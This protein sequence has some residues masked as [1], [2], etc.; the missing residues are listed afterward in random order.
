[1]GPKKSPKKAAEKKRARPSSSTGDELNGD[2]EGSLYLELLDLIKKLQDEDN[3]KTIQINNLQTKLDEALDEI[4]SLRSKVN[5]LKSSLEFTQSQQDEAKERIDKCE[6][7]QCRQEDELVRQS[8]YSRRWNLIFHGI[9]E[10]EGEDCSKLVT[11]ALVAN[12]KLE[13]K[14]A[15]SFMFCGTHRLGR[16]KTGNSKP[17]PIIARFTCRADRDFTWRQRFNLRD[18]AVKIAEDLPHNVREIRRDILIP[19]FK[20]ARETEGTKA[21]IIGDRLLING[22]KY[23]FDKIPKKWRSNVAQH[24]DKGLSGEAKRR[25]T[26]KWLREK[27]FQVFFLQEVH[28]TNEKRDLWQNEWGYKAL[29]GCDSSRKA[30][31]A[32]LFKNNFDFILNK[33]YI[34]P[35]GRFII[36]DIKAANLSFTLVNLYAPNKDDPSFF[37]NITNR[38]R[39]F[40]CDNIVIG[41]DFNLVLN[42][43][44]D[45]QGGNANTYHKKALAEIR[46]VQINLDVGDIWRDRNPLTTR[47]TWR[48]RNPEISCRLDFFLISC[49]LYGKVTNSDIT[50]GYKTD[51][52]MITLSLGVTENPRGPGLWKLNT[53]FLGDVDFTHRVK[54]VISQTCEDYKDDNNVDDALLWEMIKLKVREA[55]IFYGKEKAISRRK[56]ED[57]LHA[58][59][60]YLEKKVEEPIPPQLKEEL[61]QQLSE[62][63]ESLEKIYE[64]K[65]KGS[66]LRSKTRW[67]NEG[68]KNSSYFFNLEKRHFKRKVL[69]QLRQADNTTLTS[70]HDILQECVNFYSDLYSSRTIQNNKEDLDFFPRDNSVRL[71]EDCKD[72][73]EGLL[74]ANECL[75]AL[76]TMESNKSPG[77]D[78]FPA[79]FYKF[80]WNDISTLFVNAINC[81]FQKGLLSVTQRQGIVSLLPKK[82]KNPILLKNWRPITL[83]NCDYKIAAKAIGNR[84]KR[85]LPKIIDNDQSGFLKGRSIAENI[86]LIDGIINFADNTNKPGLLMFVDFEKAFDSIEWSFIE[87]ALIHFGFG[88]SLVNWFRLFYKDVSSAIQNNGWVSEHF[89]LGRGVRQGCPMSPYLFII[90]AEIL[91]NFIRRD[92]DIKGFETNEVEH[93]LSQYADDT[94]LILDGSEGSFLRAVAVL[95]GFH[96]ISGLKVNYEKTKVLWVGSAKEREPIKCDKSEISWV[97]GKV[98]ALGIWFATDR[99]TMLRCNYEVRIKKI[100]S[101]IE[102]WQFRRLS[103]IGKITIIKSLLVSQLV[104]ILT[105]LTT[106]VEALQKVNKMFFDFLWDGK[107]DKVKRIF[108]T[109]DYKEGGLK[110]ID[111]NKFNQSLKVSW[112]QKYLDPT[113]D[114]KWKFVFED[115]LKKHGGRDIFTCNL[116]KDDI[117]TLGVCN[118]FVQEVLEA[119]A[120]LHFTDVTDITDVNV[121]DQIIWYNSLIRINDRPVFHKHWFNHGICKIS[122][123][124]DENGTLLRYDELRIK[125]PEL[126]WFESFAVL[127]AIRSFIR[128]LHNPQTPDNN[129]MKGVSLADLTSK[130]KINHFVYTS[131]L[132]REKIPPIGSQVKWLRDLHVQNDCETRK[133]REKDKKEREE[134]WYRKRKEVLISKGISPESAGLLPRDELEPMTSPLRKNFVYQQDVMKANSELRREKAREAYDNVWVTITEKELQDCVMW[135]N[136]SII[137]EEHRAALASQQELLCDKLKIHHS[138]LGLLNSDEALEEQRR[139]CVSI[140]L[141]AERNK[142]LV[143]SVYEPLPLFDDIAVTSTSDDDEREMYITPIPKQSAANPRKKSQPLLVA[144]EV[145]CKLPY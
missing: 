45:K 3:A 7:D 80:F 117:P 131:L 122:H 22:K 95:D 105:P 32:I 71:D 28:C 23:T 52:S 110:M 61:S 6:E 12:L 58:K 40:D 114:G 104:Y 79:E 21:A 142:N 89:I 24:Q 94:T 112:I 139:K 134:Y 70:D 118:P 18:S 101:V 9:P 13:E 136:S 8:I 127:S 39:D 100:E 63:K 14:K 15:K 30:G 126:K 78:G 143:R 56:E 75:S 16:K 92:K 64:Y 43:E 4:S 144:K 11:H 82:D 38:M 99:K 138:N 44:L 37:Q 120:E 69:C 124:L 145:N 84:I 33:E 72:S 25:E 119:W 26:F 102:S 109:K 46:K 88:P 54:T 50:P 66:I 20:K 10:T 34:D 107:G 68:E 77:S 73:C 115:S 36:L 41:G 2:D 123:L 65:T 76:K 90:A 83:L 130:S 96:I 111:I 47:Y 86:L 135:L 59:V 48:R 42:V 5:E 62:A 91:A 113:N 106:S 116:H 93:K 55:S 60:A 87:R 17:R 81:S 74:S 125:F 132:K 67:Y 108:I 85:V 51:H 128:K 140:G 27:N 35:G 53:S 97:K 31:V 121:G 49:G 1:M 19:A 137:D 29:F 98:F 57:D 133:Q 141:L 103:L 129:I